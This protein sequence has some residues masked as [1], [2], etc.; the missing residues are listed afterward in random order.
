MKHVETVMSTRDY[1]SRR[2]EEAVSITA[3]DHGSEAA[4]ESSAIGRPCNSREAEI[5]AKLKELRFQQLERQLTEQRRE[6]EIASRRRLQEAR[7]DAQLA[8]M[9]AEWRK[10]AD[11]GRQWDHTNNFRDQGMQKS[12]PGLSRRTRWVSRRTGVRTNEN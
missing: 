5:Q 9:E 12:S 6:Q 11:N 1:L 3:V 10:Q 8:R 2:Q 7:D 4:I